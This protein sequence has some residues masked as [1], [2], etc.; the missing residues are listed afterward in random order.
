MALFKKKVEEPC[1]CAT[2]TQAEPCGCAAE[3]EAKAEAKAESCACAA[4]AEEELVECECGGMCPASEVAANKSQP[5]TKSGII[6][7]GTGCKKCEQLEET[8][9]AALTELGMDT[10]VEHITDIAQIAAYGVMSTPALV[11]D[12]KVASA[13]R[14]LKQK[15]VVKLLMKIRG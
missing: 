2:Q 13:G 15:E 3:S 6:V 7:L 10:A 5:V 11:I 1:A 12:G 14:N 8:T 9:I 4:E